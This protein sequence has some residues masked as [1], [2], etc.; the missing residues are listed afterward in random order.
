MIAAEF[1]LICLN[2]HSVLKA[3]KVCQSIWKWESMPKYLKVCQKLRSMPKVWEN[4]LIAI[5]AVQMLF[6]QYKWYFFGVQ[7]KY[8]GV[9]KKNFERAVQTFAASFATL[10]ASFAALWLLFCR[11]MAHV[12]P[13]YIKFLKRSTKV[14]CMGVGKPLYGQPAAVKN[15]DPLFDS[16]NFLINNCNCMFYA[17]GWVNPT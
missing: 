8:S 5:F 4:V 7:Y 1:L 11:L 3:E 15:T 9:Q 2:L 6:L 14:C 16:L 10:W 12:L 17:R 13:P